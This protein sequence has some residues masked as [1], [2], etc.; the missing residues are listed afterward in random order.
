MISEEGK[1]ACKP[2]I[3]LIECPLLLRSLQYGLEVRGCGGKRRCSSKVG[4]RGTVA[5]SGPSDMGWNCGERGREG[6]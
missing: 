1:H 6:E 3:D 5:Y 4:M 2:V